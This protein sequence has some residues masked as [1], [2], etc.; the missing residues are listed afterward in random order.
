MASLSGVRMS[1]LAIVVN[2]TII[3][4]ARARALHDGTSLSAEVREFLVS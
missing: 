4:Q 3:K 1:K 2:D